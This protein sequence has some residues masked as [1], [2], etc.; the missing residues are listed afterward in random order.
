RG[1]VS[2]LVVP[3][4]VFQWRAQP[5]RGWERLRWHCLVG[6]RG[7]LCIRRR[8]VPVRAPSAGRLLRR[9]RDLGFVQELVP[10]GR[11]NSNKI[12][13]TLTLSRPTGEG[14]ARTGSLSFQSGWIR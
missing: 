6:A 5:G 7:R 13:L 3:A 9:R 4:P 10:D 8:G 14:T 2:W 1:A 12:T 11:R